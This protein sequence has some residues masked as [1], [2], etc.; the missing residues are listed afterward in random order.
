MYEGNYLVRIETLEN[1]FTVEVPDMEAVEK[2]RKERAKHKTADVFIG[3]CTKKMA[4]KSVK[5][6]LSV[7]Q[8]ALS[9]LPDKEFDAAFDE[10]AAAAK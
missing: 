9:G 2:R 6:V 5:E 10:A 1:G 3:D 4:A 8:S 7:V